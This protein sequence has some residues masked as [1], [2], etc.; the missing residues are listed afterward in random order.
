MARILARRTP[1]PFDL[2]FRDMD[3]LFNAMLTRNVGE[4]VDTQEW[5]PAVDIRETAADFTFEVELPGLAKEDVSVV[6]EDNV[7]TLSGE[8]K[9]E[10]KEDRNSYRRIERSYGRFTRSFTLPRQVGAEKIEA[11]SSDGLLTIRV[12]K[13]PEARPQQIE[14]R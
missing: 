14:I 2:T 5:M 8:R 10:E 9:W 7:L 11:R 3:R 12:P 13:A 6:V 4:D 1:N